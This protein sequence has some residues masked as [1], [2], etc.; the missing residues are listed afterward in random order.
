MIHHHSYRYALLLIVFFIVYV[1]LTINLFL[2]Q[3][4][5][6]HFFV[7]LGKQQYE[8]TINHLYP[9]ALIYDRHGKAI[10]L[11]QYRLAACILPSHLTTPETTKEFLR[12]H[13]P[14]AYKKLNQYEKKHFMYVKRRLSHELIDLIK[15]ANLEDIKL[16]EE[17]SRFYP[18][19][20]LS[21]VVGVTDIDNNGLFGLE[22]YYNEQLKGTQAQ[23]YL[24][25]DARSGTFY[26][27]KQI[28]QQGTPGTALH[29]SIDSTLQ[30]LIYQ[31]LIK[32]VEEFKA[33]S[34]AVL[35]MD[36]TTGEILTMATIPHC[37]LNEEQTIH[38]ENTKNSIISDAY[39]AGSVF[40][41][42][43]ALA[44]IDEKVVSQDEL[45]DCQGAKTGYLDG[46][47]INTWKANGIVPF[48]EVM[49]NSNNIG[50]ATV[51]K[52]LGTKL[53]DHYERMG[54]GKKTGVDLPGEAKGY[55]NP[56]QNWSKRSFISLSFGYEVTATL[57]QLGYVF[58]MIACN[59]I[60][61][62]PTIRKKEK[63]EIQPR[64]LYQESSIHTL[65]DILTYCAMKKMNT[66]A[67]LGGCTIMGKTG[68]ANLIVN[69]QYDK[70][71]N[72]FTY[73]GIVEKNTYKRV[74][75]AFIK[76]SN[77]HNIYASSVAG[78]L[79]E[80]IVQKMIFHELMNNH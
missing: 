33:T 72:I 21:C 34:G 60:A 41:V 9:R 8:T 62:K 29:T 35:I 51:A 18:F 27:E 6:S 38:P 73:A 25:K 56:P 74:V 32:T 68:T 19:E 70:N 7:S 55:L 64:R 61:I 14:H 5:E 46:M 31:E 24:L 28:K 50:I 3:I 30:F 44:A 37:N 26:F 39:E 4:M 58:S 42:L 59:G 2:M 11:N 75:I 47:A 45:I 23:F 36:P 20:N 78:P 10:A 15:Q 76:E 52:R 17:P 12:S 54:M 63:H 49:A 16:V 1:L 22:N 77:Q 65:K 57:I 43:S 71:K 69:G 79:F 13:F 53:Y 40:K 67:H 80:R 48:K 66:I